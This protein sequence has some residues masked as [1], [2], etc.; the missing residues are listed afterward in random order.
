MMTPSTKRNIQI[1]LALAIAVA[2]IRTGWILQR[3]HE[4]NKA[5]QAIA[6]QTGSPLTIP[7]ALGNKKGKLPEDVYTPIPYIVP[8]QLFAA[9]LAEVKG[10]DPDRPRTLNKVTQTI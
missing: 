2:A 7:V 5:A 8:A 3:R 1:A 9:N 6:G 4:S 10:L